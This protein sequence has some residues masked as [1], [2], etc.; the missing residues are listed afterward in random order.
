MPSVVLFL[1]LI[2]EWVGLVVVDLYQYVG[3][4][5]GGGIILYLLFIFCFLQCLCI[6]L[7][8]VLESLYLGG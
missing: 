3:A 8:H 4:W 6:L 2:G 1:Q 5:T 7:S